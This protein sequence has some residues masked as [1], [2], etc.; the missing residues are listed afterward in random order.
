MGDVIEPNGWNF[1]KLNTIAL[2][3][4]DQE[5]DHRQLERHRRQERQTDR[6]AS[7]WT[8]FNQVAVRQYLRDLVREGHL[9][10][11][12]GWLPAPLKPNRCDKAN[13]NQGA[14]RFKKT[15]LLECSLVAVPANPNALAIAKELPR[16]LLAEIFVKPDNQ[17]SASIGARHGK[18]AEQSLMPKG[19][20][21]QTPLSQRDQSCTNRNPSACE[22]H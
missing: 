7:V 17:V 8:E 2:F 14:F 18:P 13:P 12:F 16:D 1:D 15:V 22:M 10:A 5:K 19:T 11:V 21:M 20:K 4:H 3:S 6:H 9:R